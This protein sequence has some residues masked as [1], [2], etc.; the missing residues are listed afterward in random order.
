MTRIFLSY[1]PENAICAG[2]LRT[3][4]EAQ[5]YTTWREPPY[6]NPNSAS[7]PHL[8]ETAVLGSAAVVLI[9][10]KHAAQTAWVERHLLFAQ[11]LKKPI[12]PLFLDHTS[13]PTTLVS[14]SSFTIQADCVDAVPALIA[15][16]S[17]P[18]AHSTD[19]LI[20]LSELAAHEYIRERK[21]AINQAADL[22]ARGEHSEEVLALLD[23]LATNDPIMGV[24][25][26][27]QNALV[28][29][30]RRVL[31]FGNGR[32]GNLDYHHH[33]VG[34]ERGDVGWLNGTSN[35]LVK[36]SRLPMLTIML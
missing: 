4:L 18:L 31:R 17:F 22:L 20:T 36:L 11:K 1:A 27:A 3:G 7:Y 13:L 14:A 19:A 24:R 10:S 2:A 33:L 8:I 15:L 26:D 30:C 5:S 28:A 16:P 9:W 25:E 29:H 6:P 21:E 12:F 23:S 35:V 32:A 34:V